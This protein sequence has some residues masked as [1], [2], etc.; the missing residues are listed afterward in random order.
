MCERVDGTAAVFRLL[1]EWKTTAYAPE[2]P[3]HMRF[4]AFASTLLEVDALVDLQT[5]QTAT[6]RIERKLDRVAEKLD[7][8]V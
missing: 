7:E 5:E 1:A 8:L 6:Q 4:M 2:S 3:M